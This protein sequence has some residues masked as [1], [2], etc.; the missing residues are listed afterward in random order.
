MH[1]RSMKVEELGIFIYKIE[2]F[3]STRCSYQILI[4]EQQKITAETDG[5]LNVETATDFQYLQMW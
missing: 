2:L 5:Q 1:R 4:N 3:K